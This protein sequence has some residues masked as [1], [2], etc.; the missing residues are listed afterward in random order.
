MGEPSAESEDNVIDLIDDF[1]GAKWTLQLTFKN[2]FGNSYHVAVYLP[3]EVAAEVAQLEPLPP[4]EF[5]GMS[6]AKAV[7]VLKK[8]QFRKDLFISEA[9]RLGQSLAE[10]LED[11]EGWHGVERKEKLRDWGKV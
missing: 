1:P 4:A 2:G 3:P 11:H 7:S 6:F 8:K 10:R 9:T 5:G